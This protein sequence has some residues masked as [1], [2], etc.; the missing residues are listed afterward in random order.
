MPELNL[1]PKKNQL[2][3]NIKRLGKNNFR[4][5]P[6]WWDMDISIVSNGKTKLLAFMCLAELNDFWA[7]K[8]S[9]MA[10]RED[11]RVKFENIM[12]AVKEV[13]LKAC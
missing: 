6:E 10:A 13:F 11:D 3:I 9:R 4:I 7:E 12:K 8:I 2:V 5:N 1:P